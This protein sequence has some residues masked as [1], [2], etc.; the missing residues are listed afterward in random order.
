MPN[1]AS[2]SSISPTC[3]PAMLNTFAL[4]MI[5]TLLS[6]LVAGGS[7]LRVA[8]G[9]LLRVDA[10]AGG[11]LGLEELLHAVAQE[12]HAALGA[13]DG[14]AHGDDAQLG[15]HLDHVQ[16]HDGDLLV[17]HLAGTDGALDDLGHVAGSAQRADVAVHRAAAVGV[18]LDCGAVALNN[19]LVAVALADAG[20]VHTVAGGEDLGGELVA[21]LVLGAVV[22]TELLQNLLELGH[23]G[24]LLVADLGLGELALSN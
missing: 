8:A 11:A 21:H 19:A 18:A 24:L 23:A 1:T 6:L 16:V 2:E 4:A 3:W 13:G 15:V 9:S 20:H 7:L 12:H 14:A 17:A 22:Q 5:Y 10:D